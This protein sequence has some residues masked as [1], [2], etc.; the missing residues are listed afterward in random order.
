VGAGDAVIMAAAIA[1]FRPLTPADKKLKRTEIGLAPT[2]ALDA[3]PRSAGRAGR[4]AGR[5]AA[6]G[7]CWWASRPRPTTW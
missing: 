3:N 4:R 2:I 6:V 1:D 7:R 5:G